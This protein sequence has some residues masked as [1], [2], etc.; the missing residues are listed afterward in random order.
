MQPLRSSTKRVEWVFEAASDNM[1]LAE[2]ANKSLNRFKNSLEIM[3]S[4][5]IVGEDLKR[6]YDDIEA[7]IIHEFLLLSATH[8]EELN[9]SLIDSDEPLDVEAAKDASEIARRDVDEL[10]S[11]FSKLGL[12]H[13]SFSLR[14]NELRVE[15]RTAIGLIWSL[16]N[17]SCTFKYFYDLSFIQAGRMEDD[18]AAEIFHNAR[19]GRLRNLTELTFRGGNVMSDYLYFLSKRN[20]AGRFLADIPV[21]HKRPRK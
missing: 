9:L 3:R 19:E 17:E 14:I 11:R 5:N 1:T 7:G 8:N 15:G 16:F 4:F 2:D 18:D 6:L 21:G 10:V 13:W 20:E 12:R